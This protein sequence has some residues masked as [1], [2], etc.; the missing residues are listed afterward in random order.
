MFQKNIFFI[1]LLVVL[2]IPFLGN[3]QTADRPNILIIMTDQQ[4]ADAMSIAGNKDLHTPAMDKLAQNGVRFTKAYCAQP[5]CSPS[6]AS[7]MSGK[8]PYET[9]FIGNVPEK[10]GQW[11]DDLLMMGKIFQNGG[12]KTGYVGKWHLPVPTT[13]KSQHGF[14]YIENTNFLD[15]N[16][17]AT[18]SFCARFISENKNT[19]FLLVASFLNP[20]DICEWAR[21]EDLKMDILE[22]APPPNQCPQLP[23][24][25]KIPDFEPKIVRDQQKVSFRTYPTVNW[26]ADQWR[27]YRWAYNRLVEKV[28]SYIEMVLAS[29]KKYNIEKNTIIIFTADHGD[30]YAGH[31]WNQKQILYEESA[32]IPFIISKIGQWKPRTDDMLVCNGTDI[33][34]TICGFTGVPK[35]TYLKGID[36]SKKIANPTEKLRDTLVIETDFADNDKL[37]N[38]SGRAVISNDFKYIVYNKGELKEQL[39]NLTTDP[40]EITNLAVNKTYKKE[41]I[42]MRRYLKQWCK[43]NGDSFTSGL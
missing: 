3:T 15:Y 30:G 14:E 43:N 4:T 34:P 32:K 17:A 26:N 39:F 37:M 41:L 1:W 13:K 10:D 31:S 16:D 35:P 8:M 20:H 42:A 22:K 21:D 25:W 9:G 23:A 33:I 7:L 2:H 36:I 11:P 5:L 12:Y 18:P 28:D 38:I 24:N 29:L 27:Q 6:R 19:P 40:G